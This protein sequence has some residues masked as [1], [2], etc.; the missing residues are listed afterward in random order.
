[1][2]HRE[3]SVP[4]VYRL[5]IEVVASLFIILGIG[6]TV[7]LGF[8]VLNNPRLQIGELEFERVIWRFLQNFGLLRPLL[9]LTATVLLI[10]LGL[11]LRSGYIGAARWAKSVLT[12]L[13]IL[14]GFGCLQAFFVGLDADLTSPGS[15]INGLTALVPWLLLLLVF[16]AAYIMLGSSRNFYGGDESI[17]EQSAR[18]AWNLLVPTLAVFIVIAISPLE[19]VFLSSLTDERFASSEVSQ[20]VGLDNYG[21]LLG[22]RIDPLACETNPDGTCLT[23]TR[24]GVTS[25]VYPN[26]RGV[27]GDE[28]RELRFREWTSFDFNGTHYV[29]SARD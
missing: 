26:P 28:Y 17:E 23:E 10:R 12:W 19:Q 5:Q 29:V 6:L 4:F 8:S 15:I 27:L 18:R 16:G 7:A 9:I 20:F 25:I 1:M 2:R 22:L 3:Q 21:Q 11:R 24:A 14:I 13:L